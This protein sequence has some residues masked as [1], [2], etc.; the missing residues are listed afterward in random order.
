MNI[1]LH[2]LQSNE[3]KEMVRL[4]KQ[5]SRANPSNSE[6]VAGSLALLG[7]EAAA[8]YTFSSVS[9]CGGI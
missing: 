4:L 1:A 7:A 2:V 8:A 6:I 5:C 3:V 9:Q